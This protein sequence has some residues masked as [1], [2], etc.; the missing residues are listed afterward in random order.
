M[1]GVVTQYLTSLIA[2]QVEDRSLVVWYD[3]EQAYCDAAATLE[4]PGAKV[5][6]Y[7]GS[8]IE[9]RHDIDQLLKSQQPPRL[10]VYVPHAQADTHH[11][12]IELEAAGVVMQPGQ[13][14]PPRNTRL[15]IVARHRDVGEL[16]AAIPFGHDR[17]REPQFPAHAVGDR[18]GQAAVG[19]PLGRGVH[20][21]TVGGRWNDRR[22]GVVHA[23]AEQAGHGAGS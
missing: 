3:P 6:C 11:A 21:G 9:L 22:R 7:D 20:P 2:K 1:M 17:A 16:L 4:I 23:V 15:A 19:K 14:P 8:Y 5:V 12:L 13:Q 18:E 10:V